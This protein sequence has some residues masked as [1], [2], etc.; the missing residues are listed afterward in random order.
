[1]KTISLNGF[2]KCKS[3][4]DNIGL[5]KQW[6]L[7]ENFQK[8]SDSL[9]DIEIP[10]SF[11]ML[12]GYK[13][14]EGVF[15]HYYEFSFD[16]SKITDDFDYKLKFAGS[17]YIT[18][19]WLNGGFLGKHE[20]GFTPFKFNIYPSLI[21][22]NN[23][24]VVRTDNIRRK[25]QIPDRVFDWFNWG[26]IY[27]NVDLLILRKNR[28][29]DVIIKTK[30]NSRKSCLIKI[31]YKI[32]GRLALKW[33]I[34]DDK[35]QKT[36][37]S[38][39]ISETVGSGGFLLTMNFPKL[40]SPENPNLYYLKILSDLPTKNNEILYETYFGVRQIEIKGTNIFLNKKKIILKGA[41]LHEE[42]VGY[43]RTIPYE[44][45]EKDI[46]D[47]KSLGFNAL[48]TAHYSH[49]E[50]LLDIADKLGLLILEEIPI[51]GYCDFKSSHTFKLAA[52][53]LRELVKRDIN[54]PSV[55]WWSVAN[56]IPIER[57]EVSRFIKNLMNWVR[58]LDD[59]R[60]VTYVSFRLFSDLT[61]RFADVA[62]INFYFGWYVGSPRLISLFL[63]IMRVPAFNKPWIYTE[64]G[65]G[66]KYNFHADLKDRVKFSEEYQLYV[67]DYSIRTF[68]AKQYLVG[69]FIWNYRDFRALLRQNK[70]QRGFNRKGLVS[71]ENSD[72]KLIYYRIPKI[73]NEK[74]KLINTRILGIILWIT[75]FP[76]AFIFTYGFLAP[77]LK[78][79]ERKNIKIGKE[80]ELLRLREEKIS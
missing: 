65:A 12:K 38:G 63:D 58:R 18:E 9:I 4:L 15:W 1:M 48:R 6:F 27:R 23:L 62:T 44:L 56:E 74:R 35:K 39:S 33:H 59:T 70:Y 26:G 8:V 61:R 40:W 79:G 41:N 57:P 34:L 67:L 30:L 31:N 50:A 51:W 77:F 69:W 20:G 55:I 45:R 54:R 47:M 25:G 14:F 28:I 24:L 78:L 10:K 7:P 75:L 5:E 66:A 64:F 42:I 13:A 37:Y 46:R 16:V 2:W 3:D 80:K 71:A 52:R 11:N 17:N 76:F 53:M 36:L 60:I 72:K 32:I 21:K 29:D 19:V 49:D 68:N 73:L 22:E 43:G